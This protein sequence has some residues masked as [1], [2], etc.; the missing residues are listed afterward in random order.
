MRSKLFVPCS[1]PEFFAKAID[2]AADALSFDLEDSVP[3]AEKPA[4]RA[5]LAAFLR[6]DQAMASAKRL[7]VRVNALD[8]PFFAD[9]LAVLAGLRVDL[10]NLP[11]ADTPDIVHAAATQIDA[12]RLAAGLLVTIETAAA[13]ADAAAVA[14]AHPR[15]AGLQ[16]GLNDLF[17]PLGIDR[18][19]PRH[20][21]A[22][23]W[24]IRLAAGRAGCFAYDGAWPDLTDDP[25]FRAEAELARSLGYIGKSCIHPR[26]I[27][28]AN[29]VFDRGAE[30]DRARRLVAAATAAEA[31]GKGAFVFDGTMVDAP[32]ISAARAILRRA[33][34]AA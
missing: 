10:I 34:E 14:A 8:T 21:H 7:I 5:R 33:G 22:A 27:A 4:A 31:Q 11:K 1:R 2:G 28:I 29:A 24:P 17:A 26:Q 19:D 13:L 30:L 6:S 3:P 15:V 25:G 9:D 16:V 12:L 20:V 23:L 32:A 18:N